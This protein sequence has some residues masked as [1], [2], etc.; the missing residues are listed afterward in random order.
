L[1]N[2]HI[3]QQDKSHHTGHKPFLMVNCN[4]YTEATRACESG[5]RYLY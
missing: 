4:N 1:F 2:S 3:L 5:I